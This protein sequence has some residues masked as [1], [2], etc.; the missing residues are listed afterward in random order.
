[1][2]FVFKELA[3]DPKDRSK[4]YERFT[5]DTYRI[6]DRKIVEHWSSASK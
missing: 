6:K 5:Y 1:V 2:T 4:T 3:P